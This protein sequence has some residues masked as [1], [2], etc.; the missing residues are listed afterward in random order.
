MRDVA[1]TTGPGDSMLDFLFKY[2]NEKGPNV[3][4]VLV[5]PPRQVRGTLS[6]I[7]ISSQSP[8]RAISVQTRKNPSQPT[9]CA[10]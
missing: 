8:G 2:S 1:G 5:T 7:V 6:L 4:V 3:G 9:A 10:R